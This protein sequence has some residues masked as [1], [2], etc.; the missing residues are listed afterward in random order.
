MFLTFFHYMIFSRPDH[1]IPK[2]LCIMNYFKQ[3]YQDKLLWDIYFVISATEQK[4]G[5]PNNKGFVLIKTMFPLYI[6][7][8]HIQQLHLGCQ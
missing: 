7:S 5:L 2:Q 3:V 8:L 1:I 6:C 4:N